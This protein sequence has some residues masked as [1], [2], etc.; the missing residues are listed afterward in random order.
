MSLE[1]I[2]EVAREKELK[3]EDHQEYENMYD[4]V[5]DRYGVFKMWNR[6]YIVTA[7]IFFWC[8]LLVSVIYLLDFEYDFEIPGGFGLAIAVLLLVDFPM[9][10][11]FLFMSQKHGRELAAR[12][13]RVLGYLESV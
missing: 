7:A 13:A 1:Y 6:L 5:L 4:D 9:F 3:G 2:E 11:V 8:L 10:M 12:E